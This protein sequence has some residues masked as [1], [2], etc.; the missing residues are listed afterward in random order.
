MYIDLATQAGLPLSLALLGLIAAAMYLA[1]QRRAASLA[2]AVLAVAV[3]A[4]FHNV[5]RQQVF[6]FTVFGVMAA[7]CD[8]SHELASGRGARGYVPQA[9]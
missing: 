8:P 3:L 4:I 1:F 9:M 6:W 5:L 7:S 2:M